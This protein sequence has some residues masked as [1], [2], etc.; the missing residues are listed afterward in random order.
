[1]SLRGVVPLTTTKQSPVTRQ[2][3]IMNDNSDKI[4]VQFGPCCF[5]G[6]NIATTEIDPC[7]ITVE[8][9]NDAWQVWCCHAQCFKQRIF[10]HPQIDLSPAHF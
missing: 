1:M 4:E 2:R 6:K 8:A 7:R 9:A 10:D 3:Q 5:C